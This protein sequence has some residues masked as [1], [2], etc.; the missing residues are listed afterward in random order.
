MENNVDKEDGRW[1]P[2]SGS[3]DNEGE[4]YFS[5]HSA[6]VPIFLIII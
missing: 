6:L 4:A 2:S 3:Y 1:E 5:A